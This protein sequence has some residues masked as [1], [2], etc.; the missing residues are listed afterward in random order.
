LGDDLES[1]L[2]P[3]LARAAYVDDAVWARECERIF[4]RTWCAVGREED[5]AGVGD[6]L[7]ADVGGESVVVTRS[8]DGVLHAFFNVCRHRGSELVDTCAAAGGQFA[9]AIR[10]PY[11]S[12]TYA[13]DGRLRRAPFLGPVSDTDAERFALVPVGVDTWG[14]FVFVDLSGGRGES[15]AAQLGPVPERVARYP[16]ASLG[17]GARVVYEVAANWKVLAENYNECLHCGPVHPEL[18]D[19]VPAFRRGGG[20][21]LE[22]ERGI[23]HREGAY[24]FTT[25]GTTPRAPFPDLDDDERVRHKGELV[26]P[27][28]LLSL[29]CDH[30]AAFLL[31]PRGPDH[32][33]IVF[34]LLFAPDAIA[35]P[36]FD[37]SDAL[38]LWDMV[39]RQDWAICESVQRG[40][41]SR[42]FVQG[43]FAPMEE[44]SLDVRA[45]YE[46]RMAD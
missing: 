12:W 16:L 33:T 19:L 9:G 46:P 37:P 14:G 43:W 13:L 2:Q 1:R 3:A 21:D 41:Q 23:P 7:R 26:F 22:W 10:C 27:N 24:T 38:D 15:L 31:T 28:L 36:A 35:D 32:T 18:C 42:G 4:G 40:M 30:I 29:A 20:A 45:W 39:N 34:D 25:S 6:W 8:E 5:L 11:H 44:P 17:Q